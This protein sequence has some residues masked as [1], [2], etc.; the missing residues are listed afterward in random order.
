[1]LISG[2]LG[3]PQR[4]YAPF[5]SWLAQRGHL[6]MTFVSAGQEPLLFDDQEAV[7]ADPPASL[8]RHRRLVPR[9]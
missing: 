4:F 2:G 9:S 1:V 8:T 5:A 6:V 7:F 3:I